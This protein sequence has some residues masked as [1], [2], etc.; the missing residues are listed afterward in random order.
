LIDLRPAFQ[1]AARNGKLVYYRLDSH[2]NAEGRKIAAKVTADALQSFQRETL[3][4]DAAKPKV[5]AANRKPAPGLER[6]TRERQ[7]SV[8]VRSLGGKID[9]WDAGAQRLYGWSEKEARGKVSH[10]LLQTQFPEPLEKID[11]ELVQTGEWSG[12]LVHATR[13]GR[14]VV[15]ESRWVL[16]PKGRPGAVIEINTPSDAS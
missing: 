1:E 5:P 13:D 7:D 4:A 11:S 6:S 8:M 3:E 15:V 12:K 14:R 2:W 9:F 10:Q 16:D